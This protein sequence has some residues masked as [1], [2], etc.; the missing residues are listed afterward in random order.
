MWFWNGELDLFI[1]LVVYLQTNLKGQDVVLKW[2]TVIEYLFGTLV[3][4]LQTNLKWQDV[5]LKWWT[6]IE[7]LS[8]ALVV[9]N[10]KN[11]SSF[12]YTFCLSILETVS[13]WRKSIPDLFENTNYVSKR[14]KISPSSIPRGTFYCSAKMVTSMFFSGCPKLCFSFMI[15]I[16][17]HSYS[18]SS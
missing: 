8:R 1:T 15:L 9:W 5:V 4:Y 10:F 3:V 7:D 14:K 11:V 2:W 18:L 6:A 13:K 17:F 16:L 12:T